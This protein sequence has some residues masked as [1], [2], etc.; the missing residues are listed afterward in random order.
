[1][2]AMYAVYH[3]P[4]G[5]KAIAQR[6]HGLAGVFALGLKKLGTVEVQDLGFFDTVKVKTSNAKA[7]ADA[8]VKSE[9][10][11]RVVDGNTVSGFFS[12][13]FFFFVVP[14]QFEW[15]YMSSDYDGA[16]FHFRSLL[17]LMKQLH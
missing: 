15:F 1:M 3:G 17:L 14:N 8:A 13:L 6:V 10:N 9:I 7:I 11:L 2:A 12:S 16:C 5:L 4:E